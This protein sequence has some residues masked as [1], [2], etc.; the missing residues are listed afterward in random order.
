MLDANERQAA[1]SRIKALALD[2]DGTL[3]DGGLWWSVSGEEM[4]R[5]SFVDIMGVSLLRRAGFILALISG[6]DSPLVSRYA[7]KLL[8]KDV[9]RGCRDKAAALRAF[10]ESHSLKLNEI[11]FMGDDVNDIPAMEI[12]GVAAAP[13]NAH[14]EA[15]AVAGFAC[16][17]PGGQG[18]VR[19]LAD[20]LLHARSLTCSEVFRMK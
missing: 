14:G 6:E 20:A 1:L 16:S 3:T 18:A 7:D 9:V 19:E 8:I 17:K 5:F 4:K 13:A 12:A 11:C 10:A 15:L 2:V